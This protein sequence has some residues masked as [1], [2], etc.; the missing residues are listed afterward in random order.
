MA[1]EVGELPSGTNAVT[2]PKQTNI[3]VG[4]AHYQILEIE[5]WPKRH[6]YL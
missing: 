3:G 5:F 6:P 4:Y 2:D 1:W